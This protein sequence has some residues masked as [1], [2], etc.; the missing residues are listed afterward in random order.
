MPLCTRKR[1][2]AR[3]VQYIPVPWYHAKGYNFSGRRRYNC[4]R[5]EIGVNNENYWLTAWGRHRSWKSAESDPP[6]SG[7][8][9]YSNNRPSGYFGGR[10]LDSSIQRR[11]SPATEAG[12][13]F[14]GLYPGIG[15]NRT[16]IDLRRFDS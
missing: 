14:G 6:G 12:G 8:E 9:A 16:T 3:N 2:F 15:G 10:G 7:I 13:R 1:G 5:T 4:C 11:A